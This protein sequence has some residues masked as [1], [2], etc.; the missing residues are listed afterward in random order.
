MLYF[1]AAT[2]LYRGSVFRRD[3]SRDL[4]KQVSTLPYV[5]LVGVIMTVVLFLIQ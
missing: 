1:T 3:P 4:L 2:L 5:Y